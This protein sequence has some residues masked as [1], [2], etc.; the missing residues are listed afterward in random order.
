MHKK[1]TASQ[2]TVR[3]MVRKWCMKHCSFCKFGTSNPV[4]KYG[5]RGGRARK[6]TMP[7][8][9]QIDFL[10]LRKYKW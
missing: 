2:S 5:D 8:K 9:K 3:K 1:W 7:L 4:K 6:K 10:L